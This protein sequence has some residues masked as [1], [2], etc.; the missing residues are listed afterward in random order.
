MGLSHEYVARRSQVLDDLRR[1]VET[2][3]DRALDEVA[4]YRAAKRIIA[5]CERNGV[6]VDAI[7]SALDARRAAR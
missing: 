6:S 4:A 7:Q 1:T 5:E 2:P 3:T